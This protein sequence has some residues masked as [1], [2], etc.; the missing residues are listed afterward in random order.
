MKT[1]RTLVLLALAC[2]L[3]GCGARDTEVDGI[4]GPGARSPKPAVNNLALEPAEGT[5]A[6]INSAGLPAGS[7][8]GNPGAPVVGEPAPAPSNVPSKNVREDT[9]P[10]RTDIPASRGPGP[11]PTPLNERKPM[12][13]D[14]EEANTPTVR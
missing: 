4:P 14:G 13:N 5:K 9:P 2:G 6:G 10:R 8:G 11:H 1:I 7:A 12:P 3:E